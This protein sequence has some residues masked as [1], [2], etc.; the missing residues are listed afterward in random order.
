MARQTQG[1]SGR[2]SPH[3]AGPREARW[4]FSVVPAKN[5]ISGKDGV[6]SG[7]SIKMSLTFLHVTDKKAHYPHY[8]HSSRPSREAAAASGPGEFSDQAFEVLK[9]LHL[10]SPAVDPR[11]D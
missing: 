2:R 5:G 11:L 6:V 10:C 3:G 7:H 4:Q 1:P 9:L 8:P